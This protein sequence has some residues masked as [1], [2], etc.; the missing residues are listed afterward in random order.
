M[1]RIINMIVNRLLRRAVNRGVDAGLNA[2]FGGQ[3]DDNPMTP[4]QQ[5]AIQRN[6]QRA[7]QLTRVASRMTRL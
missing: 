5:Q 2:A 7:R 3:R 4:D 6:T 1:D